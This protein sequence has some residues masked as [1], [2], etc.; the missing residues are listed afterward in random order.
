MA[1]LTLKREECE[2]KMRKEEGG[3]RRGRAGAAVESTSSGSTLTTDGVT[4]STSSTHN[5]AAND[6]L[7]PPG[8]AKW[9]E[10]EDLAEGDD[11]EEENGDRV[12]ENVKE[13]GSWDG[14]CPITFDDI[15]C[16][17]RTPPDTIVSI[18]CPAYVKNF[19]RGVSRGTFEDF[20][21]LLFIR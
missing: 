5:P 3:R 15:Y 1:V 19:M 18:A 12:L 21:I 17:P 13:N 14:Y 7:L 4:Y 2:M 8:F 9:E 20:I 16:W 6:P 10:N 11:A